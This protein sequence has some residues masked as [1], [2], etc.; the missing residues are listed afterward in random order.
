MTRHAS[1]CLLLAFRRCSYQYSAARTFRGYVVQTPVTSNYWQQ[2][3]RQIYDLG[4]CTCETPCS[5]LYTKASTPT[6]T[7]EQL[8]LTFLTRNTGQ[9]SIV[10]NGMLRFLNRISD[11][12]NNVGNRIPLQR[13]L[14]ALFYWSLSWV[15]HCQIIVVMRNQRTASSSRTLPNDLYV[16]SIH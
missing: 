9:I 4:G 12:L 14:L 1:R 3:A 13:V 7:V 5:R 6:L 8:L 2:L 15:D 10:Y 16:L 11:D